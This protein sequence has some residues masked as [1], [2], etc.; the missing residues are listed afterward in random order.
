MVAELQAAGLLGLVAAGQSG[1]TRTDARPEAGSSAPHDGGTGQ[2]TSAMGNLAAVYVLCVPAPTAHDDQAET[3]AWAT[4]DDVPLVDVQDPWDGQGWALLDAVDAD[5]SRGDDLAD[6]VRTGAGSASEGARGEGGP[7]AS[8]PEPVDKFGDPPTLGSC[9]E[10]TDVRAR[11]SEPLADALRA[12]PTGAAAPCGPSPRPALAASR[13]AGGSWLGTSGQDEPGSPAWAV[14]PTSSTRPAPSSGFT[15]SGWVSGTRR[16]ARAHRRTV[17]GALI[18]AVPDL[19]ALGAPALAA[20]VRDHVGAGWT[21]G[22]L[23]HAL[24]WTPTG[25][26]HPGALPSQP[27]PATATETGRRSLAAEIAVRRARDAHAARL[28]AVVT[29]RLGAWRDV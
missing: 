13:L 12:Q 27:A 20:I 3:E 11:G 2:D 7:D 24:D 26:R 17:A 9:V 8:S 21:A 19:A 10:L 5:Q 25:T 15:R 6:E 16:A 29:W 18:A 1:F 22:D 23:H 4:F 14:N 28:A